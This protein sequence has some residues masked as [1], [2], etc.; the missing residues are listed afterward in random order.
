MSLINLLLISQPGSLH[1]YG[2]LI[3]DFD[4]AKDLSCALITTGTPSSGSSDLGE[5]IG[6]LNDDG[7]INIQD[8]YI[9]LG[10]TLNP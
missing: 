10:F 8:L 6:D 4:R 3:Y 5:A 2:S 7:S 1:T 9:L